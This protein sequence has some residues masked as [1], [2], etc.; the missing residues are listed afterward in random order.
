M[1][2]V[3]I[4]VLSS[5]GV[6]YAFA[7]G[8]APST[9]ANR[10]DGPIVSFTINNGT[11]KFNPIAHP[12]ATFYMYKYGSYS[13]TFTIHT[14]DQS[15]QGNSLDGTTWY[16]DDVFAFGNGYCVN[17]AGPN[18]NVMVTKIVG[19]PHSNYNYYTQSVYFF[20]Y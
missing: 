17:G 9:C 2:L 14:Q 10:Y 1:V 16:D 19:D 8:Q 13:V 15:S 3:S 4:L 12:G 5:V 6:E 7:M 18:Q 11:Q 20:T